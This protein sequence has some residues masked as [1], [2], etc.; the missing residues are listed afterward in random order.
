M[1]ESCPMQ[2]LVM[3]LVAVD[4]VAATIFTWVKMYQTLRGPPE[5]RRREKSVKTK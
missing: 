2:S 4:M 1:S 5:G 3:T